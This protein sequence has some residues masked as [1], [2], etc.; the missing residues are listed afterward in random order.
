MISR[1]SFLSIA[2]AAAGLPV[3]RLA[4][5]RGRGPG[6]NESAGPLPPSIAALTSMRDRAKAITAD[7]RR[8]RIARAQKLMAE[9]KIDAI[10]LAGGT[11]MNYFT[12]MRW[13]NSE[14][15]TAV[16]I[17]RVGIRAPSHLPAA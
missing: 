10:L 5:Q 13:G 15:L 1:R 14:R 4:A 7:E 16:V 11:T 6:G 12:G 2:G 8:A 17:P 3:V 9:Q